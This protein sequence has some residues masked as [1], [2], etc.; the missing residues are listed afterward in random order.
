M[1]VEYF[2]CS[3]TLHLP[4]RTSPVAL[5]QLFYLKMTW[6]TENLQRLFKYFFVK[7]SV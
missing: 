6:M 7:M 3:A 2:M 5:T 4:S 1:Y